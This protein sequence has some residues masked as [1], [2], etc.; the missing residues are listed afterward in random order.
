MNLSDM[1]RNAYKMFI[2][3]R[4]EVS[5][6]QIKND[7][8]YREVCR[9]QDTSGDIVEGLLHKLDKDDRITIQ[10]HYEG[11]TVKE[12]YE[13]DSAYIQGMKDCFHLLSS[14]DAFQMG[15]CL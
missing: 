5:L 10:R 15:V 14:L 3:S 2:T 9:Q 1:E 13:L 8:E 12:N 4:I 7:P 6:Q 11:Q